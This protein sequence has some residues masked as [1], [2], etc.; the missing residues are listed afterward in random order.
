MRRALIG[1][2]GFVGSNLKTAGGFTDFYNSRN[3]RDMAGESYDEVVCAGV[4]AVKWLANK[5]PERDWQE[6]SALLDV[7]SRVT[8]RRFTL[9]STIDVYPDPSQPDDETTML[10]YEDG[11]PYGRHRLKIERFVEERFDEAFVLRL[12]A[13]F[14][15]GLKKNV[16]F[17]LLTENQTEKINPATVFQWYPVRRLAADLAAAQSADLKLVN[18]FPEPL[19]TR[20]LL[21]LFPGAQVAPASDPAPHYA[22]QTRY[23]ALFGGVG[24][25]IM[26]AEE[27]LNELSDFVAAARANPERMLAGTRG[28]A[29]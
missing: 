17:D 8:A 13:L 25:Y 4:S 11:Q 21:E 22:L 23:A 1:Y 12:P 6:I 28:Q 26:T 2:T 24:H 7:L 27:V 29:R 5:E 18:L 9:I 15:P 19:A 3:F 14:G 10:P 20:R 16:I